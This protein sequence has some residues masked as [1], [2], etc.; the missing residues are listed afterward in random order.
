METDA[1]SLTS[2]FFPLPCLDLK[3]P[4]TKLL[5]KTLRYTAEGSDRLKP[6]KHEYVYC[7]AKHKRLPWQPSPRF[8]ETPF[9]SLDAPP[10]IVQS[11]SGI[12][13]PSGAEK[14]LRHTL[15]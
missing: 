4:V 5:N 14:C 2:L 3:R 13:T 15:L 7:F 10:F 8:C 6:Q 12:Y 9:P 11:Y 1:I